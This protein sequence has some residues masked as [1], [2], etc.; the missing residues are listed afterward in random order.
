MDNVIVDL[1]SNFTGK[2]GRPV[3]HALAW[4]CGSILGVEKHRTYG[5][6]DH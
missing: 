2:M 6:G 5:S 3:G 4:K 1:G